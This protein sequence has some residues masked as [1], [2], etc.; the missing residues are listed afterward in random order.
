MADTYVRHDNVD[1]AKPERH[2]DRALRKPDAGQEDWEVKEVRI[3]DRDA[4]DKTSRNGQEN[5]GNERKEHDN[6]FPYQRHA[7]S[8]IPLP[9]TLLLY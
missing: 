2:V 9:R 4:E 1:G 3:N 7:I 6:S 5:T 8:T